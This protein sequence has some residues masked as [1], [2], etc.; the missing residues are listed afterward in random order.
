MPTCWTR[1]LSHYKAA[2]CVVVTPLLFPIFGWMAKTPSCPLGPSSRCQTTAD[3]KKRPVSN[4]PI[5]SAP[6]EEVPKTQDG[7][8]NKYRPFKKHGIYYIIISI[9]I[10]YYYYHL[11]LFFQGAIG[12]AG[13]FK[14][15][16]DIPF[17]VQTENSRKLSLHWSVSLI[18][19]PS[20]MESWNYNLRE[21][22][23]LDWLGLDIDL[24]I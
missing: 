10:T 15:H 23:H 8:G 20:R 11:F 19:R 7:S 1:P 9:I 3:A 4:E 18:D 24:Y 22:G 6:T 13:G 2:R 21:T 14:E 17:Q 16:I 5:S 12:Y